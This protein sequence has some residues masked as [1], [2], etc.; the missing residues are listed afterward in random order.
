MQIQSPAN[1]ERMR[2]TEEQFFLFLLCKRKKKR[3]KR[4]EQFPYGR[5]KWKTFSTFSQS[6]F[7][8]HHQDPCPRVVVA[9]SLQCH[10]PTLPT[11]I[12]SP[13]LDTFPAIPWPFFPQTCHW[14]R[15]LQSPKAAHSK[16]TRPTIR[17]ENKSKNEECSNLISPSFPT[18]FGF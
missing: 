7:H 14:W 3:E 10:A 5:E 17:K 9:F 15:W 4:E 8:H 13:T 6:G 16:I 11:T 1:D 12:P 2:E 18:P